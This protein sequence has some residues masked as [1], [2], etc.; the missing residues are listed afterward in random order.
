MT[1]K[2]GCIVGVSE[3]IVG[4]LGGSFLK[5]DISGVVKKN[6]ATSAFLF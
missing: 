3:R 6:K 4:C 2:V 5:V 1:G